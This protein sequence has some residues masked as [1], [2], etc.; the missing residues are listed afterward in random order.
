[1]FGGTLAAIRLGANYAPAGTAYGDF[2]VIT[3]NAWEL[4]TAGVFVL[5]ERPDGYRRGRIDTHESMRVGGGAGNAKIVLD[6]ASGGLNGYEIHSGGTT[7]W[8]MRKSADSAGGNLDFIGT[9]NDGSTWTP[10][11]LDREAG[12]A[13]ITTADVTQHFKHSASTGTVGFYGVAAI[14]RPGTNVDLDSALVAL[15]LIPAGAERPAPRVGMR[16][17]TVSTALV[18]GDAEIQHV[19]AAAPVTI[20]LPAT[21]TPGIRFVIKKTDA[22]ANAVTVS[23]TIDGAA[24]HVLTVKGAMVEVLSTAVSGEWLLVTAQP[25]VMTSPDGTRYRLTVG[26]DG[27]LTTTAL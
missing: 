2:I 13:V 14:A 3:G 24:N 26:D 9:K 4:G 27:A 7:R 1:M 11:S 20:T 8:R 6:G 5:D 10:L 22:S 15:G 25:Q 17:R 23:G 21:T 16:A 18:V 12:K 19:A